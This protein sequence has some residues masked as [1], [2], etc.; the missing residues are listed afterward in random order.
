[1]IKLDKFNA[2]LGFLLGLAI[3]ISFTYLEYEI[4]NKYENI[5]KQVS[6]LQEEIDKIKKE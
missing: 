1:M 4:N 6:K 2:I 5:Q 3:V